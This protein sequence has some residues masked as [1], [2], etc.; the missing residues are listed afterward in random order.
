MDIQELDDR[1]IEN[2]DK[3]Y[4]N[5]ELYVVRDSVADEI[6]PVFQAK[7][8]NV[9]LRSYRAL[10]KDVLNP[11]EYKLFRVGYIYNDM[12]IQ[13]DIQEIMTNVRTLE[14]VNEKA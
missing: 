14:V 3:L 6:G 12:T 9:A 13:S 11:D 1:D 8:A 5:A 7:N 2:V 4:I 10:M